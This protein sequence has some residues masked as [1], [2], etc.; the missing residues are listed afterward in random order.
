[1]KILFFVT[2]LLLT[3]FS[4]AQSPKPITIPKIPV[5]Y[6]AYRQWHQWPLQRIGVRA[7]M[8]STYDRGGGNGDESNF[9]FANEED[10]NVTLDVKGKGILYFFRANH[11]HGSPWHFIIDGKDNIVQETA[12]ADPENAWRVVAGDN[13]YVNIPG[14]STVSKTNTLSEFIPAAAFPKP[15]NFTWG[16]TKGAD[17]IWTPMA[18]RDSLRI[19]YSRTRYGTGY[20]IY[21]LFADEENLSSPLVS[22]QSDQL[23]APDVIDL[24]NGAGTDIAPQK[25]KKKTGRL[26]LNKE[27]ILLAHL[28]DA[29]SSIRAFK[30]SLPMEKASE[31]EQMRLVVTWDGAA[32][33]SIDAPLALFFGAGTLYNRDSVDYLVKGFP[34][35]IR[36]DYAKKKIE[37]SCYYP[38]PFF[39]SAKLELAG[40]KTGNTAIDYEI[41]Y[42]PWTTEPSLSSY[43]HAT[44]TDILSPVPGHDMVFLDTKN[45]EGHAEWAGSFAGTSFIFSHDAYLATLE[46]D[47]RF[48]F[49]DSQTPQAHG[50]G[51]EEWGGGGDYWGGKNMTLP[52]AG[53]PSGAPGKKK[54][55]NEKDLIESA[56]RFLLADVMP[57]G[58]RAIIRFE[59]GADNLSQ[60]HYKA[61]TYW[62]GLPAASL[63]KTDKLDVGDP[64]DEMQHRYYSPAASAVQKIISRYDWG[65]D[66]LPADGRFT[67]GN[68]EFTVQ[69]DSN[70]LG[71]LL[72]RTLDYSFPNQT[73]EVYVSDADSIQWKKAGTWYLAGSDTYIR[74]DPKGELDKRE[75]QV[76]TSGRQLRQ[77]EF[78][79]PAALTKGKKAIRLRIQFVNN[80]QELFPGFPFPKESAWSELKYEVFSYIIPRFRL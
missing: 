37:L 80:K 76:K 58:R 72:R 14:E 18:F 21:H 65:N 27:K 22:W 46:G 44:Y 56:Y 33:A 38:M 66:S 11:W 29:P 39:R 48:F 77:D 2:C 71:V 68:S 32:H 41:R 54:A 5:G 9:L 34:L 64:A 24:L 78:L 8:R 1:M 51:T 61:V 55:K 28:R 45:I 31:L 12:T 30:L 15:L 16:T 17:L 40:G 63:I 53:H 57:F 74:S 19:A 79:I 60:Q 47:P 3:G 73:A 69:L 50:T 42:E 35:N 59:H 67:K 20:Y 26:V 52:F 75:I 23:P 36:F 4:R 6:D 49:D 62:Y 43:F 7:Y 13:D 70:N 10:Q 25:I